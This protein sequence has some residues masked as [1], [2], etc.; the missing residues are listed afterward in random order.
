MGYKD[1]EGIFTMKLHTCLRLQGLTFNENR[2]I[3][4]HHITLIRIKV[5]SPTFGLQFKNKTES[6][7]L[8]TALN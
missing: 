6:N 1:F 8:S 5:D 4:S 2:R 7:K 3:D